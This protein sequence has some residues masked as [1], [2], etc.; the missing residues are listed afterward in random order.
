MKRTAHTPGA[1]HSPS[2]IRVEHQLRHSHPAHY[3]RSRHGSH[4]GASTIS[5]TVLRDVG[6]EV[7][8]PH[9]VGGFAL[10]TTPAWAS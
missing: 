10:P 1:G 7:M 4:Q 8:P 2:R 9:P 5:A 3:P 6:Q